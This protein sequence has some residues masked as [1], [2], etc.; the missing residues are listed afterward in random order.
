MGLQGLL[1]DPRFKDNPSRL[2]HKE[3]LNRILEEWL[4]QL[5][6]AEVSQEINPA[7]VVVGPVYNIADI[8]DDP[9]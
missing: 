8:V 5:N 4:G 1:E 3:D 9:H 7:G 6:L 2:E